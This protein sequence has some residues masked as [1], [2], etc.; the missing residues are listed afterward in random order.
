MVRLVTALLVVLPLMV[1]CSESCNDNDD[2]SD[3]RS[4]AFGAPQTT[5]SPVPVLEGKAVST[6]LADATRGLYEIRVR[7]VNESGHPLQL[8]DCRF[9]PNFEQD[10]RIEWRDGSS[11][12]PGDDTIRTA[13]ASFSE[14]IRFAKH[15]YFGCNGGMIK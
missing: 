4:C 8:P 7:F 14:K 2:P 6:H 13:W 1:G 3:P 15:P 11:V 9:H 10:A 5:S 12:K